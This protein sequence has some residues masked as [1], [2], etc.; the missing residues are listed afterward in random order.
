M[1]KMI[2]VVAVAAMVAAGAF[3]LPAFRFSAGADLGYQGLWQTVKAKNGGGTTKS[4]FNAFKFDIF[5][6][7]TYAQLGLG[8]NFGKFTTDPSGDMIDKASATYMS[9]NLL[10]KYPF[11]LGSKFTLAPAAGFDY[12]MFLSAKNDNGTLKRSD[13]WGNGSDKASAYF[14]RFIFNFGAQADYSL[15]DNLYLRGTILYGIACY[16]KGDDDRHSGSTYVDSNIISGPTFTIG[17][18]YKF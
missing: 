18:G 7:A 16:N 6:D 17:A 2:A 11:A 4:N 14:D 5:A 13:D 9:L 8:F 10:L 1:K 12:E 3:A 15:T